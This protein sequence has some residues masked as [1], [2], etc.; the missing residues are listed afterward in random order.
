MVGI[1]DGKFTPHTNGTALVVGVVMR[2]GGSIDG[3]MHT[4][5]AIDGLDATAKLAAM[6]NASP[7]KRQLRV[8]MLSGVTLAGFN[9]VDINA[10]HT[11]TGLPIIALT[12]D[13]PDLDA[14][15]DALKHLPETEER[16]RIVL[17]AGEIHEVPCHGSKV[18]LELAGLSLADALTI[19]ELTATRGCVPEPLRVAHLIASGITP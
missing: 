6:I 5:V 9:L 18:Y 19:V 14:I 10:L 16:W 4:H 7:H 12:H 13:K 8:I 1:D 2:G 11:A 17:A 15:H 3:V